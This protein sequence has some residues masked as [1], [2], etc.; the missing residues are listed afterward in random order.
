MGLQEGPGWMSL[1]GDSSGLGFT[2]VF[3]TLRT[4]RAHVPSSQGRCLEWLQLCLPLWVSAPLSSVETAPLAMGTLPCPLHVVLVSLPVSVNTPL[5][6][7]S[8][9]CVHKVN[10]TVQALGWKTNDNRDLVH[11]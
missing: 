11:D 4:A 3:V 9:V 6:Q 5:H 1:S 7:H 8:C 2:R 10:G